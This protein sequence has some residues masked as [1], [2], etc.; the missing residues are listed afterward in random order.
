MVIMY[1]ILII[2]GFM[3]LYLIAT[4]PYVNPYKLIMI[5]GKKGSGKSTIL[6]K[7]ALQY[8]KKGW[9]VYSTEHIPGVYFIQPE[10]IGKFNL[11]DFNYKPIDPDDYRGIKK[12]LIKLRLKFF[13]HKPKVLLLID[14]VGMIYDN[15]NFKNFNTKVRDFFKLQRHYYVKC[16]M[17]SQTF[18][19]DKKLRD[20]TDAMYLVKN[21]ARVFC[22]GKKIRKYQNISNDSMDGSGG[23]IVDDYEFEPFILFF[24]GSRT[25]TYIP[26]YSK[27]FNS[28]LAPKLPDIEFQC[29]TYDRDKLP[30]ISDEDKSDQDNPDDDKP[31][32]SDAAIE[33]LPEDD[34]SDVDKIEENEPDKNTALQEEGRE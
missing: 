7:Y 11:K 10:Y 5:F 30:D 26:K 23:K 21:V 4:N 9:T 16:V 17:F 15:R 1:I 27:S 34:I 32:D 24:V 3:A 28:F 14:E 6:T 19:V 22:Y 2:F 13:P 20:L 29:V 31:D 33:E 25:L 18:D 8:I 12:L